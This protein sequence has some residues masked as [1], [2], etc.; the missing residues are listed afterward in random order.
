MGQR[1]RARQRAAQI[2]YGIEYTGQTLTDALV[3]F[4][5]TQ[6]EGRSVT[7]HHFTVELLECVLENLEDIDAHLAAVITHW[8]PGRVAAVDRQILRTAVC[9]LLYFEDIPPKVTL[10]EY[11]EIAKKLS[12]PESAAFINGVLDRIANASLT[13]PVNPV[14][15]SDAPSG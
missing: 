9:E 6:G 5:E 12:G 8:Q 7:L 11:I 3:G 15:P 10:N 14:G 4:L 13:G 2:L 1:R